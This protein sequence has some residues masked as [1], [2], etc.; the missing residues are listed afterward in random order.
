MRKYESLYIVQPDVV[1]EELT[2]MVEKFQSV[3]TE[4]NAEI[5]KLDNWGTR[6]L[7]YPIK[8]HVKGCYVQT[9]FEASAEVIA[10]YERRLRLDEKILRF[11]TLRFDGDLVEA[12]EEVAPVTSSHVDDEDEDDSE[13]S[14]SVE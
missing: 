5:L 2:A 11:L 6:K 13:G 3:L 12:P 14:D 8:K 7:A 10:E 9:I 4:Q 1:G